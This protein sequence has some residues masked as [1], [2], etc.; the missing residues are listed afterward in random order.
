MIMLE[1]SMRV[2]VCHG[3]TC[4]Q[5]VKP[6]WQALQAAVQHANVAERCELIVS[7]CQS[8]CDDGPNINIY[9]KLTKYAHV[10][11]DVAE[12][13]VD[14]HIV[15]GQPVAEFVVRDAW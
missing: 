3:L 13:I 2:Y 10:T 8:R 14:E 5:R 12:R 4:S 1:T 6:I 15:A 11:V 9:P 7:G